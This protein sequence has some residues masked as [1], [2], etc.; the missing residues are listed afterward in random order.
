VTGELSPCVAFSSPTGALNFRFGRR[1]CE[2]V[3]WVRI[4]MD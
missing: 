3:G 2:N 1:L 4:L